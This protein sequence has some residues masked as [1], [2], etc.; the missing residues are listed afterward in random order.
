[1]NAKNMGKYIYSVIAVD[2]ELTFDAVPIGYNCEE[3]SGYLPAGKQAKQSSVYTVHHNGLAAVIS[4]S[5]VKEYPLTRKNMLAHQRVNE[6]VMKN[7]VVLPVKFCTIA[8]DPDIIIKRL[9]VA[10]REELL[11]K[12]DYL[13]NKGEFS[14]KVLWKEMPKV[15]S[16][17]V[18]ENIRIKRMKEKLEKLDPMRARSGLIEIGQMVKNALESKKEMVSGPMYKRLIALAVEEKQ[19]DV[20]GD[21]MVL[22]AAF[23][24]ERS[25]EALLDQAVNSLADEYAGTMDW[26]YVGPAPAANFVEIVVSWED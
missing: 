14:L 7:H 18:E 1:M 2:E 4:D 26:K 8:D 17:I 9:L 5:P 15:F 12:F 16:S 13:K 20:Y 10:K 23:L 21:R 3:P 24:V 25:K 11:S 22:N 19:N 6:F